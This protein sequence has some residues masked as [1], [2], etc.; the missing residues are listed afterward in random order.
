MN[1]KKHWNKIAPTYNEEIFDVFRSDKKKILSAFFRKYANKNKHALD[2]G[3]GNGKAFPYLAP[4]FKQLTAIDISDELLSQA[5]N[6]PFKNITYAQADLSDSSAT[7]PKVDFVFCCNVIMLPEPDK[8]IAMLG[9]VNRAL[10]KGG[11][12]VIILPSMESYLFSA[13][14]LIDWSRREGTLPEEIDPDELSGFQVGKTDLL[15]GLLKIDGV[16]T[17]HYTSEELQVIL[18]ITGLKLISLN[19][20]EYNWNSEFS[21]PPAWMKAPYPWDWLVECRKA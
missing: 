5:R 18:P 17:K 13:W 8:N 4:R 3:C 12:A 1:E 11:A 9:N 21:A 15:Q 7:L 6:S 16:P 14:R 2:F 19:K 20:V 10:R